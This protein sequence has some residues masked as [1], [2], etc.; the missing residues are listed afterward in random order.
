[1]KIAS[2]VGTPLYMSVEVLKAVAYTSKCDV[3]GVGFIFYEML[4]HKTPWIANSVYELV[5]NIESRPLKIAENLSINTKDFLR[6]TLAVKEKDRASWDDVFD[7][8]IF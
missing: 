6:K 8:P 3:W 4:H 5:N 1:M 2:S 7:H